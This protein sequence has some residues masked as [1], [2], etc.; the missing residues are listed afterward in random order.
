MMNIRKL[1]KTQRDKEMRKKYA[2]ALIV[3]Q[4]S[5]ATA[6]KTACRRMCLHLTF[7]PNRPS[8]L[9]V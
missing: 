1:R 7:C 3:K 5:I 4:A 2:N 9:L 8:F 6:I